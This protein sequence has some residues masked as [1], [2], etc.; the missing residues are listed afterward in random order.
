MDFLK[1]CTTNIHA[2]ENLVQ[3]AYCVY[4]W[5]EAAPAASAAERWEH[6]QNTLATLR[7]ENI[8]CTSIGHAVWIFGHFN[9]DQKDI[10]DNSHSAFSLSQEGTLENQPAHAPSGRAVRDI[11]LEAIEHALAFTLARHPAIVHVGP[12]LWLY[13]SVCD[14]GDDD[15]DDDDEDE[16]A[17]Q[18]VSETSIIHVYTKFTPSGG[19]YLIPNIM[20]S[21]AQPLPIAPRCDPQHVVLAPFGTVATILPDFHDES[22]LSDDAWKTGLAKALEPHGIVLPAGT[23]WIAVELENAE[24][25]ACI[26][27][28]ALCFTPYRLQHVQDHT[29]NADRDWRRWF[30][31]TEEGTIFRNPLGMAEEWFK[32]AAERARSGVNLVDTQATLQTDDRPLTELIPTN[33]AANDPTTMT[34]PPFSQRAVD[35]QAAMAGIYPTPPD[36][37]APMPNASQLNST[38]PSAT[39]PE[40]IANSVDLP[41]TSDDMQYKSEDSHHVEPNTF[42]NEDQDMLFG[43]EDEM[44]DIGDADFSFFDDHDNDPAI[45]SMRGAEL[46]H[47]L[48]YEHDPG[49]PNSGTNIDDPPIEDDQP[50]LGIDPTKDTTQTDT[51][52]E[53]PI[54]PAEH[55]QEEASQSPVVVSI[56]QFGHSVAEPEKP[57][58]PFGIRER[59]LPPPVPAS[60]TQTDAVGQ[61]DHRRSSTF[62]PINFREGLNLSRKYSMV[63]AAPEKE[64]LKP[65]TI[66]TSDIGLPNARKKNRIDGNDSSDS[67]TDD[68]SEGNSYEPS[69][70]DMDDTDLPPRLPW[71]SRKRKRH[72]DQDNLHPLSGSLQRMWSDD[73]ADDRGAG[74]G[75]QT[76]IADVLAA[77]VNST[78]V[79]DLLAFLKAD[80]E[81]EIA[82]RPHSSAGPTD[83]MEALSGP[84][85]RMETFYGFPKE[86]LIYISQIINEQ[87]V[88]ALQLDA[89]RVGGHEDRVAEL[90]IGIANYIYTTIDRGIETVFPD[91]DQCDL[92]KV[93]LTREPL[94]P[95]TNPGKA[96]QGPPRPP[97]RTDSMLLGPDYF[98]L[99]PPYVRLQRSSEIWELLP[100]CLT[101]WE[102]LGLGPTNGAKNVRAFCVFPENEDL[103]RLVAGFMTDLGTAYDNCKLGSHVHHRNV[104]DT[105]EHDT[106]EDGMA[107]VELNED[108]SLEGAMKSYAT[109][110]AELG[111]ALSNIAHQEND[112]AIVV[113]IL[114]PF[115]GRQAQQHLCACFWILFKAYRDNLPKAQRNQAGSD[116]FLQCLPISLVAS[117]DTLVVPD[118]R[119]MAILTREVYDRCPPCG[120]P[121]D[122]TSALPILSAPAVELASAAPKRI[123]FQLA[124][125][126]PT[127]LLHEGSILHIAY[128]VSRDG[129][130][131]SVCWIDNT[132]RHQS[133]TAFCLRGRSLAE[134]IEDVWECTRDI[135][136]A[137]QVLWRIFI[138]TTDT[139]EKPVLQCWRSF[140][141]KPRTQA[142]C[143]TLLAIDTDPV[144]Q[145]S[146]PVANVDGQFESRSDGGFLTPASTPQAGTFTSSPDVNG[147]GG[148]APPTPAPS[149]TAA[150]AV[151]ND[152]DAHLTDLTDETWGVLL[153][154]KLN[155]VGCN[156]G[157][158]NGALFKRVDVAVPDGEGTAADKLPSIGVSIHWTIQVKPSGGVDEGSVKQAELTLREVLRMYRNL[159]LL[160]KA[161]AI[162]HGKTS[163]V[164]IHVA[165][166]VRGAEGLDGMLG[167]S[168][169]M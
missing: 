80:S 94:R 8:L 71:E 34:S 132:G 129:H 161:R 72:A 125:E 90:P 37:Y 65:G 108:A 74:L 86:D 20:P 150:S 91:I 28:A 64:P 119:Q 107:P 106:F 145:L 136:A 59:L 167:S 39:Q 143:V 158:A 53:V 82:D 36:G 102:T 87:S 88:S 58:S 33:T 159:A 84:L 98:H 13:H 19:L 157:L 50:S 81:S 113:Y 35:Q 31:S 43:D 38:T 69:S 54:E 118:A 41:P 16:H 163:F 60:F 5:A 1:A 101:F 21:S 44:E 160:T 153:S 110:C 92:G 73:E 120:P 137:R 97:Q 46:D 32:G 103:Q 18:Q 67:D 142:I 100:T 22:V 111:K 162:A 96:P 117:Y 164:P 68:E 78:P 70:S 83:S 42:G 166:A 154:P 75:M 124:A 12:W 85:P 139:L 131:M 140:S 149:E 127:D 168:E 7:R 17:L 112:R 147:Q 11:L 146:P 3:T 116:I 121:S 155:N 148:N 114:N 134:V 6:A 152:P 15:D 47:S 29:T 45:I 66:S 9:A 99:P 61:S 2:V 14:H 55:M 104:S 23:L 63:T 123:G 128:S 165:A 144:L 51:I 30:I 169:D 57:L 115:F 27:P 48:K 26:W 56:P 62:A 93:A 49:D 138:V 130:W 126:P 133:S 25:T 4:D 79:V 89:T 122:N 10:L 156:V 24:T 76:P 105:D 151:E 52:E 141:A 135:L 95:P 40:Q 109:T 77:Y